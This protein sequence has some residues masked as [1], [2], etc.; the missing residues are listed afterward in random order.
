MAAVGLLFPGEMGARMGRAA[1]G[2]VLWASEGRSN[3]TAERAAS[4]GFR[5]VGT[6]AR[7]VADSDVTTIALSGPIGS[8]SA[9]KM[10]FG[11]WNKVGSPLPRRRTRS[12]APTASTTPSPMWASRANESSAP[13]RKRGAGPQRCSKS[14][15]PARSSAC[16]TA[17]LAARLTS[18][19]DGPVVAIDPQNWTNYSTI[20]VTKHLTRRRARPPLTPP[21]A[22]MGLPSWITL[23]STQAHRRS[24]E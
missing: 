6:L 10:A 22:C 5:D 16:P 18:S 2:D 19:T 1:S 20:S 3:A 9:L 14:L 13:E 15:T 24:L 23:R 17:S 11:G 21:H 12:R 7:L 8:A 4:A